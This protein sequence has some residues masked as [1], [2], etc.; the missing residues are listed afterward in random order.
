[1]ET[2]SPATPSPCSAACG[3]RPPAAPPSP[4]GPACCVSP[5]RAPPPPPSR[6]RVPAAA[7]GTVA[8]PRCRSRRRAARRKKY[9]IEQRAGEKIV[10]RAKGFTVDACAEGVAVAAD[11]LQFPP[12][13]PSPAAAEEGRCQTATG[14]ELPPACASACRAAC[15]G[16]VERYAAAARA[17]SGFAV[18]AD[19]RAR[20]TRVCS[21]ECAYECNKPGKFYSFEVSAR[22]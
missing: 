21:R 16:A 19:A 9:L 18:A 2:Q 8:C 10:S 4:P 6:G 1:M 20:A 7:G 22:R 17:A 14:A 15:G 12:N 13:R 5:A 11:A 3:A